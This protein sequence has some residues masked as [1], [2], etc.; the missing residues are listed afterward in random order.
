M[1]D[2]DER[3]AQALV[4]LGDFG[5]HLRAQ[6]GVQVREGFVEEEDLRV[7]HDGA[8]QRDA[9]PLAAGKRLRLAVQQVGDVER[10]GRLF[11]AALDFVLRHLA[12]LQAE[13]H[14]VVDRH[15]RV[16]GVVLEDHRDVAVLR[17]DVVGK[18]VA[19]VKLTRRDFLQAG[20]HAQGGGFAAPGRADQDDE[21]LV[22][23]LQ[24]EVGNGLRPP[25]KDL[26]DVFQ[27]HTRHK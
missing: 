3:G 11:H 14:V 26:A 19:Y 15:V 23:D 9:L 6:L 8:P 7:A 16:Q 2:I 25:L 10:A 18:G 12:Q 5:P 1:R 4:Q 21:L 24:G 17:G 22:L 27:C 20:N 13:R